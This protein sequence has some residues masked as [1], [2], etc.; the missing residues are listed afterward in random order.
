MG[1][2]RGRCLGHHEGGEG[3]GL[4]VVECKLILLLHLRLGL[5]LRLLQ[6][7]RVHGLSESFRAVLSNILP[8]DARWFLWTEHLSVLDALAEQTRPKSPL[9]VLSGCVGKF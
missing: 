1:R 7:C 3:L 9:T 2:C 5:R 8:P 6:S 4:D